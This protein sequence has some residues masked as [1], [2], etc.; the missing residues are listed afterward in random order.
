MRLSRSAL[1]LEGT[2]NPIF[3]DTDLELKERAK[4]I[5]CIEGKSHGL[6][7]SFIGNRY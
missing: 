6:R 7:E 1:G 4:V 2:A 5:C 3:Q